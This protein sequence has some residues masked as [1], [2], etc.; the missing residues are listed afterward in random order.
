MWKAL[1]EPITELVRELVPDTDKR[2]ELDAMLKMLPQ[3]LEH[4]TQQ[5]QARITLESQKSEKWWKA[6]ARPFIIWVCGVAIVNNF[7]ILP[8]VPQAQRLDAGELIALLSGILGLGVYRTYEKRAG[9]AN[10]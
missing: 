4:E 2:R 6:G 9:V 10:G 7:I 3:Q 5:M 1:V 8:Y